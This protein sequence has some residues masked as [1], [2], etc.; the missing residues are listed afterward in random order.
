MNQPASFLEVRYHDLGDTRGCSGL[1]A[2]YE[3]GQWRAEGLADHLM[4][5][6]PEFALSP[7]ECQTI[8]H[9]NAVKQI[10]TAATIV[11]GTDKYGKRGEFGELLLHIC[12]RQLFNSVPVISKLYFKSS[13]NDTVK[14]FDAVHVVGDASSLEL[15]LGEAKFYDDINAAI[16]DSASAIAEHI[17]RDYLRDEF[18][19]IAN[20]IH[21]A[22]PHAA[23][24]HRLLQENVSL[25]VVFSRCCLPVLLTYDSSTIA[26]HTIANAAYVDSFTQEIQNHRATFAARVSTLPIRIHL[27]LVP[28]KSKKELVRLVHERLTR[29]QRR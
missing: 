27:F 19:F 13:R 16:R 20:K 6:L 24:L 1:C 14:G 12:I 15:W 28:L 26:A 11:Y 17:D 3:L 23:Q 22:H 29:W 9:A 18:I 5:W 8:T 4:E 2:G 21:P 25:D 10:Q 7:E